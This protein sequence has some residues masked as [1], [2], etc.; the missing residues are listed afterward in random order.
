M[1]TAFA[2]ALAVILWEIVNEA[3]NTNWQE[4]VEKIHKRLQESKGEIEL[5]ATH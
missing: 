1:W 2:V 4:I 3:I 5:E